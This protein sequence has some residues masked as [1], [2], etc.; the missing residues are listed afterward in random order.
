VKSFN[1]RFPIGSCFALPGEAKI[2]PNRDALESHPTTAWGERGSLCG[3]RARID[4]K[5]CLIEKQV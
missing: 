4:H 5:G 2:S 3:W 1:H